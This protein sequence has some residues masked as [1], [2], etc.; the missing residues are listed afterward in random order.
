MGSTITRN[1]KRRQS[2]NSILKPEYPLE[3]LGFL[4]YTV[5]YPT[6]SWT[7]NTFWKYYDVQV[8]LIPW[9]GVQ[10]VLELHLD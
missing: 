4:V 9:E 7:Y 6:L 5:V 2:Q 3:K 8:S 10:Q 1:E